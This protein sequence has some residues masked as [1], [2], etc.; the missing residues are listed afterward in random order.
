MFFELAQETV[1]A[2]RQIGKRSVKFSKFCLTLLTM[3]FKVAPNLT[4]PR[5]FYLETTDNLLRGLPSWNL[6][7]P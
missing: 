3:R 1:K 6:I 4:H 2:I 5:V 7:F